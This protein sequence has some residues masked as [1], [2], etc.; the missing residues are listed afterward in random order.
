MERSG[1]GPRC[2]IIHYDGVKLVNRVVLPVGLHN[3]QG[4][5]RHVAH[6]E[7][8]HQSLAKAGRRPY[9]IVMRLR[10][11]RDWAYDILVGREKSSSQCGTNR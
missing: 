5:R 9:A 2:R 8:Q 3:P 10:L 11:F 7:N 4:K 1:V 6:A